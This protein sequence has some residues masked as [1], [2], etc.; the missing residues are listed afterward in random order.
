MSLAW[1]DTEPMPFHLKRLEELT[2]AYSCMM[3][4]VMEVISVPVRPIIH[5]VIQFQGMAACRK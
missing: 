2:R 3:N 5:F 4:D 1:R